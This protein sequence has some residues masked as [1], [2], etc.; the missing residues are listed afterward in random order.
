MTPSAGRRQPEHMTHA[1]DIEHLKR[2]LRLL[3]EV[4][5]ARLARVEMALIAAASTIRPIPLVGE[6]HPKP[7]G[8]SECITLHVIR[9]EQ[10][11]E[12]FGVVKKP[13]FNE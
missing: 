8:N 9:G 13:D 12:V 7:Q 3:A 11:P 1:E 2:Q 5:D 6:P 10:P 4:F